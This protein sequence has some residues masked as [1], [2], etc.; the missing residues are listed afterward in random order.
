MAT[1]QTPQTYRLGKRAPR[2]DART[3][4]LERYT[5]Q[6]PAAPK[7]ADYFTKVKSW[8]MLLNDSLGDCV[9]AA[10]GHLEL[11]WNTYAGKP[12]APDNAGTLA[13]YESQGYE[14]GDPG[15]DQGMDMLTALK[16][17][18]STG[19]GGHKIG[20]FAALRAGDY[21]QLMQAVALFGG[22]YIGLQL[23]DFCVPQDGSDWGKIPWAVPAN[24]VCVPDPDNGHCVTV[25]AYDLDLCIPV[26]WGAGMNMTP[27]FYSLCCDEAYAILSEDFIESGGQAPNG[28]ALAALQKDLGLVTA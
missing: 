9:A 26:S 23:P 12:F 14:P 11:A 19:Y 22:C 27:K 7:N 4:R 28:F 20:A 25:Q 13:F 17:W 3:L 1:P 24:G 10:A 18:R 15:T 5:Q 16:Y 21:K 6:L 2:I 8:G